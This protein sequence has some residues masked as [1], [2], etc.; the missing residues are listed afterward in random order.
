MKHST[1]VDLNRLLKLRLVV[2]RHGEMDGAGWWNTKGV[3]GRKGQL[4]YGRGFPKT[5]RFAQARVV[6]EVARARSAE[7]FAGEP[8]SVTLWS[9]P[10]HLEDA[11]DAQ[12][13]E[14]LGSEALHAFIDGLGSMGG[15]LLHELRSRGLL[16]D[17]QVSEVSK[18]RRSAEGR[19]VVIAKV[20][21][22]DDDTIALLAGAFS[23]GD[24]G[25]LAVPFARTAADA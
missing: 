15:D 19:A 7:R 13:S 25:A 5:H 1:N 6:F 21:P 11:F 2:A 22:V 10:A 18:L 3:L 20:R 16:T 14:W 17:A 12:W 8:G 24:K 4:L 9:L 23:R